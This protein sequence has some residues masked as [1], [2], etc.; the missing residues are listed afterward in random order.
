MHDIAAE[1][2]VRNVD[3]VPHARTTIGRTERDAAGIQSPRDSGLDD[4][5]RRP[6]VQ[7]DLEGSPEVAAGAERNHRQATRRGDGRAVVEEAVDDLVESAVATDR[8]DHRARL[9]DRAF[10]QLGR[11]VR[12]G[13]QDGLVAHPARRQPTGDRGPLTRGGTP[14]RNGVD[15]EKYV[16][17]AS[18]RPRRRADS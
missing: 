3:E 8:D 18:V 9:P 15:Y 5:N 6:R 17:H 16:S 13:G 14:A 2:G 10:G 11:L 4:L 1:A 12:P 7:R